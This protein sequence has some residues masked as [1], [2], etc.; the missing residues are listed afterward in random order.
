M[1]KQ[2][3]LGFILA[4]LFQ[5]FILIWM[6]VSANLPLWFGQEIKVHVRPIDPRSLFRGNYAR[7]SY[8]I[9]RISPSSSQP[10]YGKKLRRGEVVYLS[11]KQ[12]DKGIYIANKLTLSPPENEIYL[13]GRVSYPHS[14]SSEAPIRLRFANLGAFFAPKDK[15]IALEKELRKGAIAILMVNKKGKAM[16]KNIEGYTKG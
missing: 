6:L 13:Q 11:L 4:I 1:S 10:I 2:T 16:I 7:L 8:P 14:A 3:K 15:A 12:D 5:I 9:E